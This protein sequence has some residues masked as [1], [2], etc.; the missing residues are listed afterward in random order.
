[1]A[2]CLRLD[3]GCPQYHSKQTVC[4]RIPSPRGWDVVRY[5]FWRAAFVA[6]VPVLGRFELWRLADNVFLR[7]KAVGSHS[8]VHASLPQPTTISI[9]HGVACP[10]L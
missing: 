9:K 2:S 1:M 10:I 3:V 8:S 4:K 5:F 7:R 6:L